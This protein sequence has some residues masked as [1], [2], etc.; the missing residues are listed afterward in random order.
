MSVET[1]NIRTDA[2]RKRRLQIA[3]YLSHE[4]LTAFV[5]SAGSR[6]RFSTPTSTTSPDLTLTNRTST[7]GCAIARARVAQRIVW[8][9]EEQP[10]EQFSALTT[11]PRTVSWMS[12]CACLGRSAYRGRFLLAE[13]DIARPHGKL[14]V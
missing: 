3:A 10:P 1:I 13:D 11:L 14:G 8:M 9:A 4:S 2:E 5:L 6:A 12:C 7:R